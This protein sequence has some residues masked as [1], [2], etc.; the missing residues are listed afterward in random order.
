MSEAQIWE[1]AI[2]HNLDARQIRVLK[3]HRQLEVLKTGPELTLFEPIF[4]LVYTELHRLR[5]ALVVAK[6]NNSLRKEQ[7]ELAQ[8][9]CLHVEKFDDQEIQLKKNPAQFHAE[10]HA[11]NV[12]VDKYLDTFMWLRDKDA[13]YDVVLSCYHEL[14][15]YASSIGITHNLDARKKR[16]KKTADAGEEQVVEIAGIKRSLRGW[17]L[18]YL[19]FG[20]KTYTRDNPEKCYRTEATTFVEHNGPKHDRFIR[21]G[22]VHWFKLNTNTA[23]WLAG[24]LWVRAVAREGWGIKWEG[25]VHEQREAPLAGLY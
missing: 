13:E 1:F 23:N 16:K 3:A 11:I 5:Y 2:K 10:L 20:S 8:K 7:T 14:K 24:K 17:F 6:R 12:Q 19:A 15:R 25:P 22:E 18:H 4:V 9:I 21:N